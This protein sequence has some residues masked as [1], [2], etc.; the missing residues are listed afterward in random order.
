M[1][2]FLGGVGGVGEGGGGDIYIYISIELQ[3]ESE[4]T[5]FDFKRPPIVEYILLSPFHS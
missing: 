4:Q 5:G 3:C 1:C 2:I